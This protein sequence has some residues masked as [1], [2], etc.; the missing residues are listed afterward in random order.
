MAEFPL[1]KDIFRKLLPKNTKAVERFYQPMVDSLIKYEINTPVRIAGYLSQILT[2]TGGLLAV[3]EYGSGSQYEGRTDLGNTQPGDGPKY[4]GRGLIQTTGR[5]NY[6][7]TGNYLSK[8]FVGSPTTLSSDN[9]TH[10]KNASSDEQVL[11]AIQSS[12]YYF[13]K[14]SAWGDL[15][16]FCDKMDISKGINLGSLS[17]HDLPETPQEAASFK[18]QYKISKSNRF[19]QSVGGNDKN[20]EGIEKLSLGV[21]G[22][23][24]GFRSR[25]EWWLKIR[26]YLKDAPDT[27]TK[28]NNDQETSNPQ[29]PVG[30]T[31]EPGQEQK[32]STAPEDDSNKN[33]NK[34][35]EQV[36]PGT[37]NKF[38]ATIKVDPI[39]FDVN[40]PKQTQEEV[41][42]GLGNAPFVWYNAYQIEPRDITSFSLSND[43]FLPKLK[44]VFSDSQNLMADKGFPLDDSKIKIFVN[45]R[46]ENLKPIF[47]QFKIVSFS[48]NNG[49]YNIEG[50]ADI[51]KLYLTKFESFSKMTSYEVLEKIAK[52][53]GL[54]F[55]SNIENTDDRMTWINPSMAR[56]R[57]ISDY[58]LKRSYK[59]DESFLWCYVDFY[60]NLNY[61]DVSKELDREVDEQMG[62]STSGLKAA[63]GS[64][65]T[66]DVNKLYLTSDGSMKDSNNYFNRYK[67]VNNSTKVSLNKG[68]RH[69]VKFYDMLNKDFLIFDI[70]SITSKGDKTIILKGAPG[71]DEFFKEHVLNTYMGRMDKDNVHK[72]YHYSYVQ[73]TQNVEDLTKIALQISLPTPNYNIWR[74][75]KLNVVI[76]NQAPSPSATMINNRLSGGW[77]IVNI[78][79][80]VSGGKMSQDVLLV[81][82]ELELSPDEMKAVNNQGTNGSSSPTTNTSPS[83]N[84]NGD[85][86]NPEQTNPTTQPDI[87]GE[88]TNQTPPNEDAEKY[89]LEYVVDHQMKD[90]SGVIRKLVVIDKQPVDEKVGIA[91]LKMRDAAKKDGIKISIN[92]G[93]RPAFGPNFGG[94]TSKD[95]TIKIVTQESLRRDKS[96]WVA[97][98][99]AKYSSDD[100]FVMKAKSSAFNP[101]TAPPGKSN[102]GNGIALDLSTGSRVAFL[103]VL[104]NNGEVYKWLVNNSYKFGFVRAVNEEEWHFE[105]HPDKSSKGPYAIVKDSEKNLFYSD[106]GLNNISVA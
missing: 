13:R 37:T 75:Q 85:G 4:K 72:N 47:M 27:P 78:K 90:N 80:S 22:G 25:V 70:D 94:K 105:Y 55:N 43:S 49:L 64:K 23:Y 29:E 103:K 31:T 63:G 88:P 79:L 84:N 93:F 56:W 98:E 2:E 3:S 102:H 34:A 53:C 69:H 83:D 77:M 104:S 20:T 58:V 61:V 26:E 35:T 66:S 67:I 14:G 60:Y 51:P 41:V 7:K 73:N 5:G 28:P 42:S 11:N 44:I 19:F 65:E 6:K 38:K 99:R 95:R 82:R 97:S 100:E 89:D 16:L 62:I 1:T 50:V 30:A 8:D 40:G 45:S 76:S 15:N 57:F 10:R 96:R 68:Y 71:D 86:T 9:E 74:F 12:I 92:S 87:T 24:N 48:I 91:F 52:D 18:K 59:S 33:S 46:D 101:P 32:D 17:V 54:G 39:K 106:L 21:N 81:K 36:T